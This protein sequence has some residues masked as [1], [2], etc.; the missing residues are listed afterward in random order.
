MEWRSVMFFNHDEYNRNDWQD[1]TGVTKHG[2][3]DAHVLKNISW[4]TRVFNR[5]STKGTNC[6][7]VNCDENSF[8]EGGKISVSP[9]TFKGEN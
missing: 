1:Q 7:K 6:T 3:P 5:E 4:K 2:S 9:I 8:V